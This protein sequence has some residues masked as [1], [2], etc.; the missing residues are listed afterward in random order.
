MLRDTADGAWCAQSGAALAALQ[1]RS[2][3]LF[4]GKKGVWKCQ[5]TS[6]GFCRCR[7]FH[8]GNFCGP[9][10]RPITHPSMMSCNQ[11]KSI[12][13]DYLWAFELR[14]TLRGPVD[15]FT[16]FF[17]GLFLRLGTF[18]NQL[19][20]QRDDNKNVSASSTHASE[21][22]RGSFEIKT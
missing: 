11:P 12:N 21:R 18:K 16:S 13:F 17:F 1:I 5:E 8:G 4:E 14:Q 22:A 19:L 10:K 2:P 15:D 6:F 9:V 3:W 7:L 20:D